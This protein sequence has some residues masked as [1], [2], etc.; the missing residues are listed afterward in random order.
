MCTKKTKQTGVHLGKGKYGSVVEL[1]LDGERVAGKIFKL[2]KSEAQRRK[3]RDEIQMVLHLDHRNI[4]S[5]KGVCFLPDIVL[6]VLLMER[7]MSSLHNFVIDHSKLSMKQKVSILH[8]V[9]N[10]LHYLHHHTPVII[11]RDLTARNVLLN[12]DLRA[13]ISDFGNAQTGLDIATETQPGSQIDTSIDILSFGHLALFTVLQKHVQLQPPTY[14]DSEGKQVHRSEEE[15][16][17]KYVKEAELQLSESQSLLVMI[18]RCLSIPSNRP[19]TG[20]LLETL[21]P[22][23]QSEFGSLFVM[24]LQYMY[25]SKRVVLYTATNRVTDNVDEE[26]EK[27]I[28]E[29]EQLLSGNPVLLAKVK[30][31][32]SPPSKHT[33]PADLTKPLPLL[34][35][36]YNGGISTYT[37]AQG[38]YTHNNKRAK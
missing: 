24:L 27:F 9:V 6:P 22:L 7:L 21:T 14:H 38:I 13:K 23:T 15:R 37:K 20:A 2:S 10:G 16:R 29:A 5:S 28:R 35:E 1:L 8:D 19:H 11:H 32:F 26:Q 18:K 4:V 36:F 3:L 34:S 30:E 17:E 31:Y 33:C 12:S 25:E